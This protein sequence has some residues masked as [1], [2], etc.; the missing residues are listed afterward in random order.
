[1]AEVLSA[2]SPHGGQPFF[3]QSPLR[4]STTSH[5]SLYA[6][7]NHASAQRN[8]S[9]SR[10]HDN[11][12]SP[13]SSMIDPPSPI[14]HRALPGQSSLY[15]TPPSS[16][17]LNG[18]SDDDEDICF[19]SYNDNAFTA[20]SKLELP[21]SPAP[22]ASLEAS[23]QNSDSTPSPPSSPG[24]APVADDTAVRDE[25]SR[26]VDYL[27]HDWREEDIWCSWRHIVSKRR[28]YGERS[29]LENASWRTW[30]KAKYNLKTISPETLNWC[31]SV[32]LIRSSLEQLLTRPLCRLKDCDVTWLYGPLQSASATENSREHS[33][34]HQRRTMC[35][36]NSFLDK[37]PIL[38]KRTAS[39]VMLQKSISTSSLV[40]TAATAV[41]AQQ[42][43]DWHV[44]PR[45]H[46][47]MFTRAQSSYA[48]TSQP[49]A[50]LTESSITNAST[51][52]SS[53]LHSPEAH[54]GRHIRFDDTVEQRIAV[55]FKGGEPEDEEPDWTKDPDESSEEELV[56]KAKPRRRPSTLSSTRSNVSQESTKGIAMLPSTTLKYHQD[57]PACPGHPGQQS[58]LWRPGKLAQSSSQETLRPS[59]PSANFLI[60][61]SGVDNDD[62]VEWEPSGAFDHMRRDSVAV[63]KDRAPEMSLTHQPGEEVG[64]HGLRRTPSG[65]FM[66][67]DDEDDEDTLANTG[68]LGRF[69]EGVN[70][71]RDI[72]HVI[73]NVGWRK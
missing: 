7:A 72:A 25:P 18:N 33:L 51:S 48:S 46:R 57:D 41:Q 4:R 17:C 55:D 24:L 43:G 71:A 50:L 39:E 70:T 1:M 66:P 9:T 40:R 44:R 28:V 31:V 67:F 19:P 14:F 47:P 73:W 34:H 61:E 2:S 37:K 62:N 6:A 30:A 49:L 15:S 38:K 45:G 59:R 13:D 36:T 5:T 60:S 29:R 63:T 53:G 52:S 58:S 56:M 8:S 10:S 27:S 20:H 68:I 54:P 64:S 3:Q 22:S 26:H 42:G 21:A 23:S 32:L 16:L 12:S 35:K 65:M 11:L 69:V